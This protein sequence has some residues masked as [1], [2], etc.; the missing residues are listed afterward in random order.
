MVKRPAPQQYQERSKPHEELF[1]LNIIST[2]VSRYVTPFGGC[3]PGTS[4]FCPPRPSTAHGLADCRTPDVLNTAPGCKGSV[5]LCGQLD[6]DFIYRHTDKQ[7]QI[8]FF[9]Q[10]ITM[11]KRARTDFF[12]PVPTYG[13]YGRLGYGKRSLG[14]ALVVWA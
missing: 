4:C 13:L 11:G 10:R 3:G 14:L 6:R 7:L 12:A 1:F 2:A 5:N 8:C 9:I